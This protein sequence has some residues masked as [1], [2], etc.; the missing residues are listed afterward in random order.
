MEAQG[1]GSTVYRTC[2]GWGWR[3]WRCDRGRAGGV[4][5][6]CAAVRIDELC[7]RVR[8]PVLDV[9]PPLFCSVASKGIRLR[10]ESSGK[11]QG[12]AVSLQ[13]NLQQLAP[14]PLRPAVRPPGTVEAPS[15]ENTR[16]LL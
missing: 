12:K 5:L 13:A 14:G 16:D 3:G 7:L 8:L 10:E 9:D 11:T 4:P 1:E 6:G 15:P 2:R